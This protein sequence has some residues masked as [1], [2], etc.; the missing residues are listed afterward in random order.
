MSTHAF[1][2]VQP[3]STVLTTLYTV[4]ASSRATLRII[5]TNRGTLTAIRVSVALGGAADAPAQYVMYD[6]ILDANEAVSTAPIMASA[7][8]VIRVSSASGNVNFHCTGLIQGV[9]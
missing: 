4:P 8:D 9:T 6:Q 1:V 7:G 3:S 5:A 2:S